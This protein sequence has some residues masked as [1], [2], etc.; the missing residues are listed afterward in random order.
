MSVEEIVDSYKSAKYKSR[1][2][3]VLAELNECSRA[4]M[5]ELLELNGED[6][7][8]FKSSKRKQ[9]DYRKV[10]ELYDAGETDVGIA[11]R[12]GCSKESIKMWRDKEDLDQN[13][14]ALPEG[15]IPMGIESSAYDVARK[16]LEAVQGT[17]E[18][19]KEMWKKLRVED[20]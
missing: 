15:D 7:K 19:L 5:E 4:E 2:I 14:Q 6:P 20:S 18:V 13:L 9:I 12:M 16:T 8:K 10:R 1:Q 11:Y 3:G 17:N